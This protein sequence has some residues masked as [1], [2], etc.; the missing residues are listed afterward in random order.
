MLMLVATPIGNLGDITLRALEALKSADLIAC[1]DT[2]TTGT[3]LRHFG[4]RTRTVSYHEHN[5]AQSAAGLVALLQ[6]GKTVALVSDAGT[7]LLSDPGARLVRAAVEAGI[8]VTPL[9]GASALLA[10]LTMSGL[11]AEQFYYAGFLPQKTKARQAVLANLASLGCTLVF[12]EAPHRLLET[13]ADLQAHLGPREAAVA[14]ELTK[15][16]EE[17]QRGDL[18]GLIAHYTA[19]PPRGECV[20]LVAGASAQESMSDAAIDAALQ[21]ALT[22]GSLKQAVEEVTALSQRPRRAIYQRALQLK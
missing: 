13:L 14:R 1:E 6:Q 17:C 12:Y 21:E 3:L 22:R 20:I 16:Y 15:L 8:Q 19:Q 2:R 9:P 10:G 4:I 7:P 18:P 11:S 5:E